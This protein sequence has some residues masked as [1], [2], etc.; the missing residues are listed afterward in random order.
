MIRLGGMSVQV[1]Q[2]D[3]ALEAVARRN[4]REAQQKLK[5]VLGAREKLN[6]LKTA[7]QQRHLL[8]NRG[9][10]EPQQQERAE[11]ESRVQKRKKRKKRK[12]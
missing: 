11:E 4:S 6:A 8:A 12:T 7:A 10:E 9:N 2:Q 5:V 3:G 1:F